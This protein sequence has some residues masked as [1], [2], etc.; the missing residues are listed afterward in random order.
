MNDVFISYARDDGDWAER[1][2]TRLRENGARVFFDR[3]SLSPGAVVVHELDA[4][5]RAATHGLHVFSP[6][7][8]AESWVRDEYAALLRAS[9]T[10]G[11]RFIP[12]LYGDTA[13]P[14]LA[15]TRLWADFRGLEGPAFDL[16]AAELARVVR[17]E[18]RAAPEEA[19]R[20]T[21]G[22]P[23]PLTAPARPGF[24]VCYAGSDA[25]YGERLA[26]RI[27][28]AGLPVW[29]IARLTW[30]DDYIREIRRQLRHAVAIIVLMSPEAEDSDDMTRKILE[31]QRHGRD[32]FPV[33]L[34]GER[35]YL[36]ASSWS[37]DARAGALP[38]PAEMRLLRRLHDAHG[39]ASRRFSARPR[40]SA[41]PRPPAAF[42]ARPAR[43][44]AGASPGRL[45]ALLA[46]GEIEHADLLTTAI[47]LEAAGRQESGWMF[48]ADAARLETGLLDEVNA[49]WAASSG[50]LYGFEAQRRLAR[51]RGGL[52]ADF[53]ELSVKYGW[54]ASADDAVPRY[55]G[56]AG[57]GEG[58]AGFF[59]TLRNPQN[60]RYL[61]WYD[62]WMETVLA[63][64]LRLPRWEGPR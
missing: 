64:H 60:E 62:Q 32:F 29:S 3:W 13:I 50:G 38:G 20:A 55:E 4:A 61:D 37:F 43:P 22:G 1:L 48:Q 11:L 44:S 7:S 33:L 40:P 30:G 21:D 51:A 47:L 27:A 9:V 10:R 63:V 5:L 8:A 26:G 24:V 56:F 12:V 39:G 46:E 23:T 14:P 49:A 36:L 35:H 53:L 25:G 31:G 58:R 52:H 59:P 28:D 42:P 15:E 17:G 2:A 57:R 6:A 18:P 45:R 41:P 19:A 54:R 34:R 16:K